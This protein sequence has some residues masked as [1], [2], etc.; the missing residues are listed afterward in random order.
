MPDSCEGLGCKW[1]GHR[2]GK[3]GACLST[4]TFGEGPDRRVESSRLP[5]RGCEAGC[6][7]DCGHHAHTRALSAPERA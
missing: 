1:V 3:R 2:S 7:R 5:C 6:A 4:C